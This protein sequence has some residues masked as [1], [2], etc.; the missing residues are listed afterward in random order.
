MEANTYRQTVCAMS[1][2][3]IRPLATPWTQAKYTW[4]F[5]VLAVTWL[6]IT[7]LYIYSATPGSG[8]LVNAFMLAPSNKILVLQILTQGVAIIILMLFNM[9]L[10]TVLWAAASS[11]KGIS[12]PQFLALSSTTGI[13]G[14]LTLLRWKHRRRIWDAHRFSVL[15]R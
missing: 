12:V 15:V 10:D 7:I 11:S 14:L 13:F 4:L 6:T 9:A 3:Y 8:N 1:P 2:T 5:V